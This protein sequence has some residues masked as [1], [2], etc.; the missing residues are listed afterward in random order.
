MTTTKFMKLC[1]RFEKCA[2][3]R[4]PLDPAMELVTVH[5]RDPKRT[6]LEHI[7]TRLEIQAQAALEGV[8][9]SGLTTTERKRL[10]AGETVEKFLI[11]ADG[12]REALV[13]R[14][15]VGK[16]VLPVGVTHQISS[17]GSDVPVEP[18]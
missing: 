11:E 18:N 10:E 14:L 6:C 7:R 5:N 2:V 12:R 8:A 3:N 9:L 1:P 13:K 17:P 15:G 4:C 16:S